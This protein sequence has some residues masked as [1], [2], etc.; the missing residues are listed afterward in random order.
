MMD[1][2]EQEKKILDM[3]F[4]DRD[5]NIVNSEEPDFI[6][7]H[8]R[9]GFKFGIE[10]T[11]FFRNEASARIHNI[12]GY[13]DAVINPESSKRKLNK[14]DKEKL[15]VEEITMISDDNIPIQTFKGVIYEIPQ[16]CEVGDIIAENISKKEKKLELYKGQVKENYLIIHD[17][18]NCLY[19]KTSNRIYN[20][21]SSDKLF[22]VLSESGFRDIFFITKSR[23]KKT[24][25]GLIELHF[26]NSVL[27]ALEF[28]NKCITTPIKKV[29]TT[30]DILCH[31]GFNFEWSFEEETR[32]Y[33]IVYHD[34]AII[35]AEDKNHNFNI[36]NM[37]TA[38]YV[39]LPVDKCIDIPLYKYTCKST[40]QKLYNNYK[41]YKIKNWDIIEYYE[42]DKEILK[43]KV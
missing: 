42:C 18:E 39:G 16:P 28:A 13:I 9:W 26:K 15:P 35:F 32:L 27:Q 31:L 38:P 10:I 40:S 24:Y 20:R 12:D 30:F 25:T 41:D 6:L 36:I 8:K 11:E 33:T 43:D 37:I 17:R 29:D 14:G 19:G 2:K 3:V 4:S 22:K 7:T 5:Y 1:K 34:F 23:E 21:I